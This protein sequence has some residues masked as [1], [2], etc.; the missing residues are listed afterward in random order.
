MVHENLIF[1]LIALIFMGI[2]LIYFCIA[3]RY[4]IIDHPNERSSHSTITLRGGGVI[5]PLAMVFFFACYQFQYP[6]FLLGLVAISCI[7][8]LD[9]AFTLNNTLRLSVH[10]LSVGLLFYQWG[11]LGLPWYW[12]LLAAIIVIG[13]INAYNFMDGINGITGLY[14]VAII[15]SLLTVNARLHF[16]AGQLLIFALL[17]LAIFLYFN[18]RQQ[19]KCFAGDVGSISIAFIILFGMGFLILQ[20]KQPIY[21]LFLAVYGVD[22]VLTI[23]LR[24]RNR[25]NIF[26]PHRSHLYQLLTNERGL[27]QRW[28]AA[29]YAGLQFGINYLVIWAAQQTAMIQLLTVALLL[30][31]L[32]TAYF[33]VRVQIGQRLA[34]KKA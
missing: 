8:F 6:F 24:I 14:S 19:A 20:T 11:I 13:T 1:L 22:S 18:F 27:S 9:D 23:I 10:L 7:S 15:I 3:D 29:G 4:N 12:L 32:I 31:A 2:E 30:I 21:I 17:A 25:E 26:K 28:V 16:M 33:L 34:L 5:F